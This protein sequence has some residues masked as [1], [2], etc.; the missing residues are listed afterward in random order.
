MLSPLFIG[1]DTG[2]QRFTK[3][4]KSP[5]LMIGSG[6]IAERILAALEQ[7]HGSDYGV[8]HSKLDSISPG[9]VMK[10]WNQITDTFGEEGIKKVVI[11]MDNPR[12]QLPIEA[13]LSLRASGIPVVDA[14]SFYEE[15]SGRVPVEFLRPS[16]LI[17]GEGFR[18]SKLI[19]IT[20]RAMDLCFSILGLILSLP[21]FL[22]LPILIKLDSKGPVF[23]RQE[24]VGWYGRTFNIIKFRTMVD[25]AEAVSGPVW[26]ECND[27][28]ITRL[29]RFMR[30]Y[31]L[32]ELPQLINILTGKMSFV[33]PRPERPVFVQ[34]L[35]EK[36]P[37][38]SLR[39]TV[40]PG[41]TGWA[42]IRFQYSSTLQ[43]SQEKFGHDLYYIKHSS[44]LFDL[45]IIT[46]TIRVV[47]MG[48]GAK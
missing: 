30:R 8:V 18:R 31:R 22:I 33:G 43:E 4:N 28:R 21:F 11:A 6:V 48:F 35:R 26:A 40:K 15:I 1:T 14:A 42:Q 20:K 34:Q 24:R 36:I 10:E 39:F 44:P 47:L 7:Y 5:I 12:T 19:Y 23:Y 38:Y 41:L 37:F 46:D 3:G 9:S 13:L 25:K 29:G 45:A 27:P 17:F 32:D 16:D 2:V